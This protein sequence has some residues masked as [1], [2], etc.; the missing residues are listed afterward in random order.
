M[1]DIKSVAKTTQ[2]LY[3]YFASLTI[4]IMRSENPKKILP[5][6]F[7][8]MLQ[9]MCYPEVNFSKNLKCDEAYN[10][11]KGLREIFILKVTS[12]AVDETNWYHDNGGYST[13]YFDPSMSI[14]AWC[15]TINTS[16][17]SNDIQCEYKSKYIGEDGDVVRVSVIPH[18]SNIKKISVYV[19]NS[20]FEMIFRKKLPSVEELFNSL[21]LYITSFMYILIAKEFD[22]STK[23]I[24]KNAILE[25]TYLQIEQYLLGDFPNPFEN[26][27]NTVHMQDNVKD[28]F[29]KCDL[30][31]KWSIDDANI[32]NVMD[33][34]NANII[35]M[36]DYYTDHT[37]SHQ[38]EDGIDHDT[39]YTDIE[40]DEL[41]KLQNMM[42]ETKSKM[43]ENVADNIIKKL[44]SLDVY[45]NGLLKGKVQ[46]SSI[47]KD[48]MISAID[49]IIS[50]NKKEVFHNDIELI[51]DIN[52]FDQKFV[53]LSVSYC[54]NGEENKT[55][56]P[57]LILHS[58]DHGI[59]LLNDPIWNTPN[60]ISLRKWLM[61]YL[62]WM[63]VPNFVY[64][65][66][67]SKLVEGYRK[68]NGSNN[69]VAI[70]DRP[71]SII[72]I[73]DD[74]MDDRTQDAIR[75]FADK[76]A[77]IICNGG[78]YYDDEDD[79]DEYEVEHNND[80]V[81]D[82]NILSLVDSVSNNLL[83]TFF[84][85][86]KYGAWIYRYTI[87]ELKDLSN[88]LGEV[89]NCNYMDLTYNHC[90]NIH[91]TPQEDDIII[92]G[93]NNGKIISP[94]VIILYKDH[95]GKYQYGVY[96]N[97]CKTE[98]PNTVGNLI[99]RICDES[100]DK[101][102]AMVST[103]RGY[104]CFNLDYLWRF[105]KVKEGSSI[106]S[107]SHD[108]LSH[109]LYCVKTAI[110]KFIIGQ[111]KDS[112]DDEYKATVV[113]EVTFSKVLDAFERLYKGKYITSDNIDDIIYMIKMYMDDKSYTNIS[114]DPKDIIENASLKIYFP[115]GTIVYKKE[116]EYIR[117]K[118]VTMNPLCKPNMFSIFK[119]GDNDSGLLAIDNDNS[120]VMDQF[121]EDM[122]KICKF[123]K[124]EKV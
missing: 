3:E 121:Y 18:N 1:I 47:I 112:P 48:M 63:G 33:H 113:G 11:I 116:Q 118:N 58:Q 101:M 94:N 9:C 26:E 72:Q 88:K 110:D 19:E 87:A 7:G 31:S 53:K 114:I 95:N 92:M 66:A 117:L 120:I 2:D 64:E 86:S 111:K 6:V 69:E 25:Y 38:I 12:D 73:S 122:I 107:K 83:H 27:E 71:I 67:E 82:G 22:N 28:I 79:D 76:I 37:E 108:I 24:S 124:T 99:H 17:N 40:P 50:L 13:V 90:M 21:L 29:S 74:H 84:E 36:M 102:I 56:F 104:F 62:D 16:I 75:S 105:Y 54:D 59:K 85:K 35:D 123:V 23:D 80:L 52:N 65:S 60:T 119:K 61:K 68:Q 46:V 42:E 97:H 10:T 44:S 39:E 20:C 15:S 30:F 115:D 57:I 8:S 5:I 43:E 49:D 93:A 96:N 103:S 14:N 89:G 45:S 109:I 55:A 81:D 98:I 51:K 100:K 34:I 70:K 78:E 41:D 32:I 106:D 77:D 91:Y 4:D